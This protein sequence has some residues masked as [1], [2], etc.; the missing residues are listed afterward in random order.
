MTDFPY[1]PEDVH[2]EDR[3]YFNQ[4]INEFGHNY[5][6]W[7]RV[8]DIGRSLSV[9]I[10]NP[11]TRLAVFIELRTATRT[12]WSQLDDSDIKQIREHLISSVQH[13]LIL[14]V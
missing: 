2:D 4:L 8:E 5:E 11:E 6:I 9:G 14:R 12:R 1:K 10:L 13:D 7:R 3:P